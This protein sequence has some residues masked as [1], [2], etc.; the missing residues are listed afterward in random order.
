ML[1][2]K[3]YDKKGFAPRV[4]QVD[5]FPISLGRGKSNEIEINNDLV[6]QQHLSL[7]QSEIGYVIEDL[8]S[9]NGTFH[10]G[11][12]K[13]KI[14]FSHDIEVLLADEVK[15]E[16]ISSDQIL[17][18]TREIFIR[19]STSVTKFH[20]TLWFIHFLTFA[21]TFSLA[22]LAYFTQSL[23]EEGF[24]EV[25]LP[26]VVFLFFVYAL[27][28]VGSLFSKVHLKKYN[29][30]RFLRISLF[31]FV[32][33]MSYYFVQDTINFNV[34]NELTAE[35]IGLVWR[36]SVIIVSLIASFIIIFP[37]RSIKKLAT[38]V[39]IG[40]IS[41]FLL[42]T[43]ASHLAEED[44]SHYNSYSSIGV[45]F[46]PVLGS[47]SEFSKISSELDKSVKVV[48]SYREKALKEDGLN[49]KK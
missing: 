47:G 12:R 1:T 36:L 28:I 20:E 29:F 31:L 16:I 2:L 5:H 32:G 43:G 14:E 8:R 37:H 27:T 22:V 48:Q 25:I 15:I 4:I 24:K 44:S 34:R 11:E 7:Y 42:L 13:N 17:D 18:K 33:L 9:A 46:Y 30:A 45:P 40:V 35:L 6:S 23:G 26:F 39:S 21:L 3:I 41:G 49:E 38:W 19:Q 10:Q